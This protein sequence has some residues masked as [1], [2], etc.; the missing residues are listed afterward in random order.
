MLCVA[1]SEW[2]LKEIDRVS[3][4][5]AQCITILTILRNGSWRS[6]CRHRMT[7]WFDF[8]VKRKMLNKLLLDVLNAL[9]CLSHIDSV[10]QNDLLNY[11]HVKNIIS[12]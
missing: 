8:F 3:F 7:Y 4:G 11:S 10:Q 2:K 9:L 12:C 1:L 6:L 5:L